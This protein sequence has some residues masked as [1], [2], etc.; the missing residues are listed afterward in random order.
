MDMSLLILHEL[1]VFS[2]LN[3]ERTGKTMEMRIYILNITRFHYDD[4][5]EYPGD[6]FTSSINFEEMKKR[7]S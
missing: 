1:P 2:Y 4:Y 3:S 7:F 6:W 5:E